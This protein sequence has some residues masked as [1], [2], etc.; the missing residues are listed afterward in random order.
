MI[1]RIT[2]INIDC[3]GKCLKTIFT[4]NLTEWLQLI[5]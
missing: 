2:Y 5:G 4:K 3:I 1:N